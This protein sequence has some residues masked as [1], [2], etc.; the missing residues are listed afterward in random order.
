MSSYDIEMMLDDIEVLLKATLNVKIAAIEAEK[1]ALGIPVVLDPVAATSY[2]QQNWSDNILNEAPA[3]FYGVET[4][5]ATGIGP[6]TIEAFKIFVEIV[7]LD[8][9][10]DDLGKRRLNRYARALKEVFQ[11]NF[12]KLPWSN[13]TIVETVRPISFTLDG[14]TSEEMRVGGVSIATALA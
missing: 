3:I 14:N 11:E 6:A 8:N 12:D 7:M 10:M 13:K 9:G 1:T 4:I 2:F 5:Q